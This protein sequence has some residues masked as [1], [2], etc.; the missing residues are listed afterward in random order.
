MTL[1]IRPGHTPADV[2]AVA[3]LHTLSRRDAYR[4]L[5]TPAELAEVTVERQHQS[6][7]QRWAAESDTHRM[8]LAERDGELLGFCYLGPADPAA[9][10]APPGTGMLNAIHVRPDAVGSGVG[11]ALMRTCL[12]GFADLG[13]TRAMLYVVRE[14]DRARR[15]YER[16]GWAADGVARETMIGSASVP[17]VRYARAIP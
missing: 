1:T 7:S 16:G 10:Q 17:I 3:L 6:W 12:A 5:L 9:E 8:H 15:F 14:N 13:H 11:L 4:D 2:A